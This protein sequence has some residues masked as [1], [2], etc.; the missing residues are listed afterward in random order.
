[1]LST[2][3]A[4]VIT[5]TTD[6]GLMDHYAGTMKGIIL[7]RCPDARIVD[8]SHEIA[9]FSILEGAY[10]IAQ[11]APF[12]PSATVHVVVVDPGVGTARRPILARTR[13]HYFIAPDNG[14]LSLVLPENA[15]TWEIANPAWRLPNA[16]ETFHGRD[17]FA[18]AAAAI[19]IGLPAENAGPRLSNVMTLPNLKPA[20]TEHGWA[21]KIFSVDRFG[22]IITNLR[23]ELIEI[24]E[25]SIECGR[26]VI[27]EFRRTFGDAPP[28]L[29]FAYFGSS[30]YLEI[31]M[32]QG[33][34]AD[35]LSVQPGDDVT[36]RVTI[37]ETRHFPGRGTHDRH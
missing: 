29:C 32:N 16:S 9:P 7:S 20:R 25:L 33:R 19:A 15:E 36:L 6:F 4:P 26:A 18:P 10:T 31:G 34:A 5:L 2:S 14:V 8:I 24:H 28:G 30:G 21:G 23:S 12:F 37:G 13:D 3:G 1:M 22:N 35:R 27:S 11:S 17:I